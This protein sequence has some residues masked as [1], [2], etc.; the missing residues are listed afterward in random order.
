MCLHIHWRYK[1]V[2]VNHGQYG[3]TLS[4]FTGGFSDFGLS[5]ANTDGTPE[6][7]ATRTKINAEFLTMY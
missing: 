6:H 5:S 1:A 2:E 7:I 3:R 4:A